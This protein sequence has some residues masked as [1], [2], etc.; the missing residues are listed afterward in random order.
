MLQRQLADNPPPRIQPRV[1]RNRVGNWKERLAGR[2][3]TAWRGQNHCVAFYWVERAPDLRKKIR[4]G[5]A[6]KVTQEG[7]GPDG[8]RG[9]GDSLAMHC[10]SNQSSKRDE[11]RGPGGR[12][13]R[14]PAGSQ[15]KGF[16]FTG[17]ASRVIECI[18]YP[19]PAQW[20][21]TAS[22]HLAGLNR[23]EVSGCNQVE[24]QGGGRRAVMRDA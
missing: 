7:G 6:K 3:D 2:A 1:A 11:L 21:K 16:F 8:P 22:D 15:G 12:L 20:D 19:C 13:R 14:P 23:A 5:G 18:G 4:M 24:H 10:G 9:G 17:F